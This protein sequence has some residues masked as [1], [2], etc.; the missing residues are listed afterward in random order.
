MVANRSPL[1]IIASHNTGKIKE[2]QQVLGSHWRVQPQADF[3]VTEAEETGSTFVENALIKARH[4]C[5]QTGHAALA[6]DSG[7]VVAALGGAPGLRSARYSGSGYEDNNTLLL[8]NMASLQGA[9][10][11]AFYIAVVVLLREA[12]DPTPLIA[13]GRWHGRIA[14]APRGEGGF[15][16]DPIFIPEGGTLHAAELSSEEKNRVSHRA[17]AIS[18]LLALADD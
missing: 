8:K 1:L 12:Q 11:Q 18:T 17:K 7:L 16:Y 2:F 6:D 5:L 3:A 15:G 14:N 9:S 10:R 4:A 13:E